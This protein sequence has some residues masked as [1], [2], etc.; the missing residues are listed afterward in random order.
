MQSGAAPSVVNPAGTVWTVFVLAC[1]VAALP[2]NVVYILIFVLVELGYL[3]V[4]ASYLALADGKTAAA[5]ALKKASGVFCFLAGLV[6]W[7]VER[8]PP[9]PSQARSLPARGTIGR[10]TDAVAKVPHIRA[11]APGCS[12]RLA[13]GR[14]ITVLWQGEETGLK[15]LAWAKHRLLDG[16]V[17]N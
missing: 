7:Y 10:A 16:A 5:A 4:A 1:L 17:A 11:I 2:S 15:R 8:T 6:G 12:Y 14:H 9:P 3:C 13:P